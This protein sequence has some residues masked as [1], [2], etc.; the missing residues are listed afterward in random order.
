MYTIQDIEWAKQRYGWFGV[1]DKFALDITASEVDVYKF[2][3]FR[4]RATEYKVVVRHSSHYVGGNIG[5]VHSALSL[6]NAVEKA[7]SYINSYVAREKA[8]AES[9]ARA[10]EY[11]D[12]H[13]KTLLDERSSRD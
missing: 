8:R 6:N 1:L 13:M 11:L 5:P 4:R 10:S 3:F 7:V 2:V 9:K 12:S